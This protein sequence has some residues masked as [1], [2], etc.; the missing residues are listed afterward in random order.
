MGW[1]WHARPCSGP[2]IA[3]GT[4]MDLAATSGPVSLAATLTL[5][6]FFYETGTAIP[7]SQDF[8][9]DDM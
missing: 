8:N 9:E 2:L 4:S 5:S 6:L 1:A 3:S 7:T